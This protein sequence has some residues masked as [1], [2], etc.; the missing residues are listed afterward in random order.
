[1][2]NKPKIEKI[3][4]YIEACP[5]LDNGKIYVDYLKD[6]PCSYSINQT[7]TSPILKMYSDGGSLRQI[8]FDFTVQA[9]LSSD[10]ITNLVNSKFCEDFMAWVE[11]QNRNRVL[12]KI[13]GVQW[14]K[15][16]SPGYVLGKTNTTAI[17]II[18]MQV[19][20]KEN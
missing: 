19:V 13:E 17:Y 5:L 20:Y 10:I 16:A 14:V 4:K 11:E 2:E 1:M 7:P 8:T 18:Q 6:K 9:P 12:P 15:C 3:K